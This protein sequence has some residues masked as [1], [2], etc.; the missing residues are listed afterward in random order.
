MASEVCNLSFIKFSL[1]SYAWALKINQFPAW[2][3]FSIF[4]HTVYELITEIE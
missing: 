2:Q 3:S 4:G 1:I